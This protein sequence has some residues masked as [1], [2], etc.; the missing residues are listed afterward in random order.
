M[1]TS[2]AD[3]EELLSDHE[4][5]YDEQASIDESEDSG[6]EFQV[7][8]EEVEDAEDSEN[9]PIEFT[10]PPIEAPHDVEHNRSHSPSPSTQNNDDDINP[11]ITPPWIPED[12]EDYD[13]TEFETETLEEYQRRVH[14]PNDDDAEMD[15]WDF[16][17]M[18]RLTQLPPSDNDS[19]V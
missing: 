15:A 18:A 14:N 4:L 13:T 10:P 5:E 16:N 3:E 7:S 6:S 17:F 11:A 19:D 9:E 12:Y 2:V 8:D 1:A